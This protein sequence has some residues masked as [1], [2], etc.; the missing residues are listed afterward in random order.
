MR[1]T[2]AT[3]EL[4]SGSEA[5]RPTTT[6]RVSCAGHRPE[7]R[8]GLLDAVGGGAQHLGVDAE[9]AAVVDAQRIGGGVGVEHRGD[10]VLGMA[11]GEQHAGHRQHV[12]DALARKLSRPSRRMGLANSR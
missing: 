1:V 4:A 2:L 9:L 3:L 8:N 6:S 7:R 5:P 11:G 12:I 10:V